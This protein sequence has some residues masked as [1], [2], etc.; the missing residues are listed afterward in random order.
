MGNLVNRPT[1]AVRRR[2]M[3]QHAP[4][5]LARKMRKGGR[6]DIMSKLPQGKN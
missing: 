3:P 2:Q 6:T 1:G 5:N 4:H